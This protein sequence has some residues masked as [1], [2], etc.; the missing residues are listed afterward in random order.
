[1]KKLVTTYSIPLSLSL[2]LSKSKYEWLIWGAEE[3]DPLSNNCRRRKVKI[4]ILTV[5]P[6]CHASV[7]D[8]IGNDDNIKNNII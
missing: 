3:L 6:R 4:R 7:T 8:Q 1:M 2:Y 5:I